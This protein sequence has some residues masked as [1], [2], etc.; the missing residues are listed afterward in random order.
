MGKEKANHGREIINNG[1]V[2]GSGSLVILDVD[3]SVIVQQ[4]ID[5]INITRLSGKVKGRVP[6]CEWVVQKIL[7]RLDRALH[8]MNISKF[9]I[10]KKGFQVSFALLCHHGKTAD[11]EHNN[12]GTY[13][14]HRTW[15][16]KLQDR[17]KNDVNMHG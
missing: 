16:K 10:L 13:T 9:D 11:H 1:Q 14:P 2:Q 3:I 8:S 5:K 15:F 6:V 7:V 17:I 12:Q 4:H